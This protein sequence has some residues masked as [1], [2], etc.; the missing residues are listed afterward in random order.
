MEDVKIEKVR[1]WKPPRNLKEVQWFLGFTS[2]YQYF[3]QGYLAI[4]RPLLDLTRQVTPWHW[5]GPQQQVFDMLKAQMCA[6][7]VL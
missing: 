6:K 1:D 2:Y 4:V 7:P 5:E 3:I